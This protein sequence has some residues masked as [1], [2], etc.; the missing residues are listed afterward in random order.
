[1]AQY[2]GKGRGDI[3][4]ISSAKAVALT[5]AAAGAWADRIWDFD[6][7][8]APPEGMSQ[9]VSGGA[10]AHAS[11]SGSKGGVVRLDT[12]ATGGGNSQLFNTQ[13]LAGDMA[14]D[15]WYM[16]SRHKHTTV[17]TVTASKVGVGAAD[18]ALARSVSMGVYGALNATNFVVQ[19]G[20]LWGTAAIDLGVAIESTS[21]HLFEAW[22]P[23]GDTKIYGR[24]D[25]GTIVS[26]TAA[27]M[28]V[29]MSVFINAFNN[30]VATQFQLDVDY[31]YYFFPR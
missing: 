22:H 1:M 14:T 8:R 13:R 29:E 4:S 23:T 6:G 12:S 17:G 7:L 24:I 9:S 31:A 25:S 18:I 27:T 3:L 16:A 10:I 2:K 15:F 21:F 20:S 5:G 26:A 28:P 30:A 11:P 19:F